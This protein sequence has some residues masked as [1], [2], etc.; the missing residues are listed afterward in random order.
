MTPFRCPR[1]VPAFAVAVTASSDLQW[2]RCSTAYFPD[3][4]VGHGAVP[5]SGIESRGVPKVK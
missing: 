3:E 4:I 2:G 5:G 1:M